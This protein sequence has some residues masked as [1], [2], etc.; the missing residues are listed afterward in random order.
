MKFKDF[1]SFLTGIFQIH[2][3][4]MSVIEPEI[5]GGSV[6]VNR[7]EPGFQNGCK[8]SGKIFKFRENWWKMMLLVP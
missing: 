3:Q 5:L 7:N 8:R 1:N 4:I 6:K 2:S